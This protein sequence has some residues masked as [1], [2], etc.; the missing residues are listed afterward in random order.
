MA[1]HGKVTPLQAGIAVLLTS[2][3]SALMNLPIV[4]RQPK[5]RP[6]MRELVLSSILQVIAGLGVAAIQWKLGN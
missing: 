5:A 6:L 3:A 1:M 2:I 4:W